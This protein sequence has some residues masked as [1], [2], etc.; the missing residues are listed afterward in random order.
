VIAVEP[1]PR[2]LPLL[3]RNLEVNGVGNSTVM[4]CGLGDRPGWARVVLPPLDAHNFGAASLER[5]VGDETRSAA[6]PEGV[7]EHVE[8]RTL[9]GLIASL[10]EALRAQPVRVLKVDVEGMQGQV[11]AGA[12]RLID[13]ERPQILIEAKTPAE[14]LE[15]RSLLDPFGYRS[16]G[17]FCA[18]A[19][20]YLID[21]RRHRLRRPPIGYRMHRLRD[22]LHRLRVRA[23]RIAVS[24]IAE[25]RTTAT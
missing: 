18:S 10:P 3:R 21:P 6:P 4:G 1:N 17:R 5:L 23:T 15:M 16:A 14:Q 7:S 20:Y 19:T 2:V 12:A 9:D 13:R 25:T 22:R 11:L 24:R 8:I